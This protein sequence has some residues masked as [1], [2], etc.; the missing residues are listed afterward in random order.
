M[1]KTWAIASALGLA[2]LAALPGICLA[3]QISY[4][5]DALGRVTKADY[6]GGNIII[7]SYD[8]V[9][10]RTSMTSTGSQQGSSRVVVLPLLGGLVLPIP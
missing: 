3:A 6:G 4:Q 9:G 10:N 1:T 5:Y 7:Y 2:S 8:S